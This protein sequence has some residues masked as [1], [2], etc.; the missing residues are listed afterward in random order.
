MSRAWFILRILSSNMVPRNRRGSLIDT[1]QG[2][3]TEAA[4]AA[5][6]DVVCVCVAEYTSRRTNRRVH[7]RCVLKYGCVSRYSVMSE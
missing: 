6:L 4:S 2:A 1:V 3:A 7:D 5:G